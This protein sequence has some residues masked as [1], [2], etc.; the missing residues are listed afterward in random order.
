M[1]LTVA[2]KKELAQLPELIP[3]DRFNKTMPPPMYTGFQMLLAGRDFKLPFHV[4]NPLPPGQPK[5]N[6]W[7]EM[8]KSKFFSLP[9]LELL[10]HPCQQII[11]Q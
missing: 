1:A 2:K 11:C 3:R 9:P 7:K 5:P 10:Q 4:C 6:G 8:T